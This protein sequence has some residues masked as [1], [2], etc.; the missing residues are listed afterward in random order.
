MVKIGDYSFGKVDIDGEEHTED[1]IVYPDHVEKDWWRKEGHSIHK[2]DIDGIIEN[3]PD[4]FVVGKG[5]N[6][7]LRLLPETRRAL[8]NKGVEV[9]CKRTQR[10]CKEFNKFVDEGKEVV[11]ALHL[12]C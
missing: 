10:A 8:E 9:V 6:G 1:L 12:T 11:A 5:S 7:R 4:I 2:E 3:P